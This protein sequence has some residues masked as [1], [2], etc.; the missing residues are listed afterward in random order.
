MTTTVIITIAITLL[1]RLWN[2]PVVRD[3]VFGWVGKLPRALQFVAP[4]VLAM[5]ASACQGWIDGLRGSALLEWA[6]ANG[7][8]IGAMAIG[9]WH[10]AKRLGP[11]GLKLLA[12]AAPKPPTAPS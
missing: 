10:T 8:Q 3:R 9:L 7:G 2:I 11:N 5:A 6:L 12:S 4:V 1:L